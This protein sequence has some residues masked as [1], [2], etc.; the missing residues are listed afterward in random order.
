MNLSLRYLFVALLALGPVHAGAQ[1]QLVVFGDSLS[2]TGNNGVSTSGPNTHPSSQIAGV[3][4]KQLA[5]Q[6]GLPLDP[7]DDGGT[8]YARGGALT[9]GMNA[10]V[11]AYLAD[12]VSVAN[13]TALYIL[14]GGPNDIATKARSNPFDTAGVR[15]S[16]A[17]AASNIESQI[18]K[19]AQAG[20]RYVLW[21]NLPPLHQT[22]SAQA[23][24][25]GLG[26]VVLKPATDLFNTRWA[27]AITRLQAEF[28]GLTL[29]GMDAHA[30]YSDIV[31]R[32]SAYGFT[33]VTTPAKGKAVNPDRYLFW[34]DAHPTSYAH[35]LLADHAFQMIEEATS[36]WAYDAAPAY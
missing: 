12:V 36:L 30:L 4:V 23:I 34:D 1:T 33:N 20:A 18:R 28:P 19:L 26:T 10:Q 17:T 24:P 32:P 29:G 31:A 5:D 9:S 25:F 2:D 35:G 6:L 13:P 15:A 14:W 21:V 16:A 3:W 7:S 8:D 22:P 27:Q 11:N